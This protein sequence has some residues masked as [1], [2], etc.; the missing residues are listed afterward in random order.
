M[1]E[2][3]YSEEEPSSDPAAGESTS[4]EKATPPVGDQEG[5]EGQTQTPAPD[6][7]GI[8]PDEEMNRES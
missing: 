6:D 4:P 1:G 5:V 2:R 7:T 8:P 3:T